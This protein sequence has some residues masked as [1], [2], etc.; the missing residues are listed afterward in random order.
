MKKIEKLKLT[1]LSK[2]ALDNRP[3]GMLLGGYNNP[4][5]KGCGEDVECR[6]TTSDPYNEANS[7]LYLRV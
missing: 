2:N 5:S 4:D 7:D 3:M 6:C 1:K